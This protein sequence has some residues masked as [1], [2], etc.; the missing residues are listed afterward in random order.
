M[1]S[2]CLSMEQP[3]PMIA[4]LILVVT[5]KVLCSVTLTRWTAV[6]VATQQETGSFPMGL[7]SK[8]LAII[9]N[10]QVLVSSPEAEVLV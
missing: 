9:M 6:L 7:E 5:M 4:M 2:G 3:L 1:E 10:V 8:I